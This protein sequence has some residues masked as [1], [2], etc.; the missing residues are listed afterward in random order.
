MIERQR[1]W[2]G[3]KK[4]PCG[5]IS[6][7]VEEEASLGVQRHNTADTHIDIDMYR[8]TAYTLSVRSLD[9]PSHAFFL[10]FLQDN[11]TSGSRVTVPERS[12]SDRC[13][14]CAQLQFAQQYKSKYLQ[15]LSLNSV[16][17]TPPAI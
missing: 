14:P 5:T 1:A 11:S 7:G 3:I 12:H 16:I 6:G 17:N 9:P 13:E 4:Q 10:L 15:L 8:H 2:L